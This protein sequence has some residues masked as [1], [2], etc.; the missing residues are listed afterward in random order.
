M[1][2]AVLAAALLVRQEPPAAQVARLQA[3]HVFQAAVH[4]SGMRFGQGENSFLVSSYP[5]F[6]AENEAGMALEGRILAGAERARDRAS[7]RAL[8]REFLAVRESRHRALG[9]DFAAFEQLA[10]LNEGL[11]EYALLRAG[12]VLRQRPAFADR[13]ARLERLT[14]NATQSIR[15]R[16]YATGPAQAHLLDALAGPSWKVRLLA[17]NLTLQDALAEASG[18]RDAERSVRRRAEGRVR[19]RAIRARADTSVAELRAARRVQVDSVLAVP[20]IPLEVTLE[21]RAMGLCGIDPQNLLQVDR[22]VLLHT[23]WVQPCAGDALQSTF[24][25]PVVQDRDA[26][27]LRAVIGPDSTLRLTIAGRRTE[28]PEGSRLENAADVQL[29]SPLFSLR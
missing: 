27:S 16:Y 25:T 20:R 1:I 21:G 8:A 22:G 10:E 18:F 6:D 15:L 23:R 24:N 4:K 13:L 29:E 5:V 26:G 28:L 2:P 3:F 14:A 12:E 19:M 9:A 17:E 11:A 7:K